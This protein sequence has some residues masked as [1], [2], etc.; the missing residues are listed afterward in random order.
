MPRDAVSLLLATT[1]IALLA[2][3]RE[4]ESGAFQPSPRVR[5]IIIFFLSP[6]FFAKVPTEDASRLPNPFTA[7]PAARPGCRPLSP[8]KEVAVRAKFEEW[9]DAHQD[10]TQVGVCWALA[11]SP[12]NISF[13]HF[14]LVFQSLAPEV[15]MSCNPVAAAAPPSKAATRTTTQRNAF[16]PAPRTLAAG[17]D[18][19]A[20]RAAR[21]AP[22]Q[23]QAPVDSG[24]RG[25]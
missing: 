5:A 3:T 20:P 25:G 6:W 1:L 7:R 8:D 11:A 15:K 17:G 4:A 12:T 22:Q 19:A 24:G 14:T 16:I 2:L 9:V 18:I 21:G 23:V 13:S 10:A